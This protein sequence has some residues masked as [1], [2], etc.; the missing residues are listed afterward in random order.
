MKIEDVKEYIS[1]L[2]KMQ[3][4]YNVVLYD[5][6]IFMPK[7]ALK[8]R[9]EVLAY[10][11]S[12]IFKLKTSEKVKEI[13][14]AFKDNTKQLSLIEN[15]MIR[16]L[17]RE[18]NQI[19]DIPEDRYIEY[20]KEVT[21]SE[22][23]WE[24]AKE[25]NDFS[26]Y[27]PHLKKIVAFMREFV[28]YYGYKEDKYDAL[29]D[30]YE[31]GMTV[32]KLDKIF[33]ELK[34]GIINILDYVENSEKVIDRQFLKEEYPISKQ[35]DLSLELLKLIQFDMEAGRL[36]ETMHPFTENFWNKDVRLTTHYYEKDL[37]SNVF[38][39]IHEGGHGL[40]E[41]HIDDEL[42]GTGL[43]TGVSMGIHE[44]QSRFYE[45]IIGRSK[46][47]LVP[48]LKLI[49]N[50]F[51][52][53]NDISVDKF[54]E[55]VNYVEPSLIRTEADELTYNL[56]IIIRYEIEK[57]LIN[58]RIEV[59]NLPQIWNEKYKK[60]LGIEPEND[61]EGVLQDVH[62]SD[63]SF[64]YF[65]SYALGNIY[66]G[67]FLKALCSDNENAIKNLESGDMTYI[68]TWL[69][70]N[71]HR[72]GSVYMP[73]QLLQKVTGETITTK[74]YIEYLENKYKNIF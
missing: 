14:E 50:N 8:Q 2:D 1:D 66:S 18:Y 27:E 44:S 63:G 56:H 48:V 34:N 49:K 71:I 57:D 61:S 38:S 11:S 12:Q 37:L 16:A 10:L 30:L 36:D 21:L 31:P 41:Q 13:I 32:K 19:K 40:Y 47:F 7:K 54:Y 60:Y 65:P 15:S 5:N 9:S 17:K 39:I 52:Q 45:N 25:K 20:M 74:Y 43:G 24:E 72:Y 33:E 35:K 4:A 3:Y 70:D 26:I 22:A 53:L 51:P 73:E 68:N 28:E 23:S 46:E 64:G 29:L 69:K 6:M 59:E 58:G 42:M 62:W 55:A 67:M